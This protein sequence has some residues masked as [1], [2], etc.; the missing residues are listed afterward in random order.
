MSYMHHSRVLK[1]AK[2]LF[3][4]GYAQGY[5]HGRRNRIQWSDLTAS[6]AEINN[7]DRC[8]MNQILSNVQAYGK[9]SVFYVPCGECGNPMYVKETGET[10]VLLA[11]EACGYESETDRLPF[12]ETQYGTIEANNFNLIDGVSDGRK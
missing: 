10:A 11:C 7:F 12:V 9:L 5:A 6:V 2:D 3:A 4:R 8:N 1:I